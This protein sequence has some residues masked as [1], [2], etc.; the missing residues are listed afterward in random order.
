[1]CRILIIALGLVYAI[2]ITEAQ[3]P[4]KEIV[5]PRDTKVVLRFTQPISTAT[6]KVGDVLRFETVE[7]V[8]IGN[9]LIIQQG[10]PATGVV[11]EVRP[12]RSRGRNAQLRISFQSV[13][14]VDG[15][16]LPLMP[17]RTPEEERIS[18]KAPGVSVVGAIVLG[19]IGLVSGAFIRGDHITIEA[20]ATVNAA[21]AR[22]MVLPAQQDRRDVIVPDDTLVPLEFQ[23]PVSTR[24]AEEGDLVDFVVT[25][26]VYVSGILIIAKGTPATGSVKE[27]KRPRT[28][29]R[30]GKLEIELGSVKGVDGTLLP[31]EPLRSEK[32]IRGIS[33]E[34]VGVSAAGVVIFGPV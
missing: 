23:G 18:G 29:G 32:G 7:D 1:M 8:R 5:V 28:L 17:Y 2:S 21:I 6:A 27:V 19:P 9:T 12:P 22:H 33:Q 34:A 25:Q 13:Q 4:F 30:N 16:L 20:G 10:S 11:A 24:T 31:L 14:A 3:M 15:S 26:D